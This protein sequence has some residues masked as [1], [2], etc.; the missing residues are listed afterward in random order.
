MSMRLLRG[1]MPGPQTWLVALTWLLVL[2]TEAR[3]VQWR[4]NVTGGLLDELVADLGMALMVSIGLSV[5]A[6]TR[7]LGRWTLSPPQAPARHGALDR[8][9]AA[10]LLLALAFSLLVRW[11]PQDLPVPGR[12][13]T[14]LAYQLVLLTGSL[15]LL[16][17]TRTPVQGAMGLAVGQ[18]LL[19]SLLALAGLTDASLHDNTLAAWRL[20]NAALL[21]L[22]FVALARHVFRHFEQ[23]G[24]LVL[25]VGLIALGVALNDLLQPDLSALRLGLVHCM[26][27]GCLLML[28]L[29]VTGRVK[30]PAVVQGEAL[31]VTSARLIEQ[32]RTRLARELHDGVGSQLVHI[33]SGLDRSQPG[34]QALA[35]ALE[36]CLFEV[37]NVVDVMDAS[38][39]SVIDGLGQLRWRLRPTLEH[40]GIELVWS[41]DIDGP[42]AEV[43]GELRHEVLRIAQEALANAVR[44]AHAGRIVLRCRFDPAAQALELAV[45]DDG[46]GFASTR[47]ALRGTGVSGMRRRAAG[48]G[49]RLRLASSPGMGTRLHLTVPLP[50][51]SG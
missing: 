6:F 19:V 30:L 43:R 44:H 13:A 10:L 5:G 28:W 23:A 38:H 22:L 29:L 34:Q 37:K 17:S 45:E 4:W 47:A 33:L 20:A 1:A 3:I 40:M 42:L 41:V 25:V 7:G 15:F 11:W 26:L 27:G 2:M 8:T 18:W 36:A 14:A 16:Q 48:I 50:Q 32:E 21:G 31:A 46:E 51:A 35:Q 9:F 24:G 12:V 39:E 49:G